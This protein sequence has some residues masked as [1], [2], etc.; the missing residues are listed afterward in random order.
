MTEAPLR[1]ATRGSALARRQT[2][3]VR[4]ALE[5][6]RNEV[7][8]VEVETR[9]DRL[10]DELITR[11]GKTGAF[12]RALD[13]RVLDG[14]AEA[15][16]HSLKDMPTEFPDRLRVGGV[17]ERAPS[18]DVV[19]TPD[20]GGVE[21]LPPGSVVGTS[22]LRRKAQV[23]A[24]RPDLTVEPLR[25]NVDTRLQKL[26]APQLQAEHERRV[27][28]ERDEKGDPG[29]DGGSTFERSVEEWF[30]DLSEFQRGALEYELDV[31]YDA[32]VLA[33][34]GL[35]RSDL[36]VRD[37]YE[38][39]RLDRSEF[40]PAPGQGAV[41][42]TT[43]DPEVTEAVRE[44]VDHPPTRVA[45]TVERTVLAELGGGC[46]API[47]VAALVQGE[48]VNAR[49]RVLST[50]GEREVA[51]TRDLPVERHADAAAEFAADLADR[52]AADIIAEAKREADDGGEDG[53]DASPERD[54]PADGGTPED[55][56]P[57]EDGT[58]DG[59]TPTEREE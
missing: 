12:V 13:Q 16:V 44:A 31:E 45:T 42:V 10:T 22:S 52:G 4:E 59:E 30:D 43:A 50:D 14:E 35:R 28:A 20:G 38:V 2:A 23:L 6:R 48:H 11:L 19:V 41:A 1:L 32:I 56:T 27:D 29:G 18:G 21:D 37:E 46:V 49:V 5:R 40:V 39:E 25:G 57:A 15:A 36:Y 8:V 17:G 9:G 55:G 54:D 53:I 7:E 26:V 47:G 3:D 24:A 34:A 51:A 33:E 58:P